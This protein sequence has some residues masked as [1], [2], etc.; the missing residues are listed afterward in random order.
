[1][2]CP[3]APLLPMC[4][5]ASGRSATKVM[6]VMESQMESAEALEMKMITLHRMMSMIS[7]RPRDIEMGEL[8]VDV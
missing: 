3:R 2:W 5:A 1:M 8:H 7:M 4:T 6:A